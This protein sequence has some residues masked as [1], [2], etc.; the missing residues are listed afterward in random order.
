MSLQDALQWRQLTANEV[1]KGKV[2]HDIDDLESTKVRFGLSG[3]DVNGYQPIQWSNC[4]YDVRQGERKLKTEFPTLL[5]IIHNY[6]PRI[7]SV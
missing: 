6:T 2:T 4:L 7:Y 3:Q 1:A 5:L